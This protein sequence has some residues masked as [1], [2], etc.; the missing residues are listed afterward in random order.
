MD[1]DIER[2][3]QLKLAASKIAQFLKLYPQHD[4]ALKAKYRRGTALN[5]TGDIKT[6][7]NLFFEIVHENKSNQYVGTAAFRLGINHFNDQQW[8]LALEYFDIAWRQSVKENVSHQALRYKIQCLTKL[9]RPKETIAALQAL[10][11]DPNTDDTL[12]KT[13]KASRKKLISGNGSSTN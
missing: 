3:A 12:R 8:N 13:A 7:N 2:D 4:D 9:S 1:N 11:N 5:L 10:I 6:A